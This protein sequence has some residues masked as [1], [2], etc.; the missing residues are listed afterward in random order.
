MRR[1]KCA[2]LVE[3]IPCVCGISVGVTPKSNTTVMLRCV[4]TGH[5]TRFRREGRHHNNHHR[6]VTIIKNVC[7]AERRSRACRGG[8][9]QTI[10]LLRARG[11]QRLKWRV[12]CASIQTRRCWVNPSRRIRPKL[13]PGGGLL[14]LSEPRN[15]A[16]CDRNGRLS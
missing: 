8:E 9:P 14:L 12:A 15:K 7:N 4:I 6:G 10:L 11:A 13:K 3:L 1:G 5:R 2:A 16:I